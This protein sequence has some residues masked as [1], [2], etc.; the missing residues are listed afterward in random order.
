[1]FVAYLI[2]WFAEWYT[3]NWAQ[4]LRESS[5]CY[6]VRANCPD[7]LKYEE[8]V[9]HY[10]WLASQILAFLLCLIKV[11]PAT[12]AF[13]KHRLLGRADRAPQL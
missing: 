3:F 6:Q 11:V 7:E 12:R 1:M 8:A 2:W 10:G 5:G 13:N 9:N 4:E